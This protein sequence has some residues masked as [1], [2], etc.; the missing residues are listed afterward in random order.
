MFRELTLYVLAVDKALMPVGEPNLP[1]SA[2]V[3]GTIGE[4]VPAQDL[5][6]LH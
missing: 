5:M 3:R 4:L 1:V 6:W 2:V